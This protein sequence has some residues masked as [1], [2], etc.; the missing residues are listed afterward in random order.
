MGKLYNV[1][2]ENVEFD[3]AIQGYQVPDTIDGAVKAFLLKELDVPVTDFASYQRIKE[4][5]ETL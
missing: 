2:M 4:L 3:D 5:F 1:I